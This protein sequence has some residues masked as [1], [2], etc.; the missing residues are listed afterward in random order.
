MQ[1]RFKE[2]Y[3]GGTTAK[4]TFS[5][6]R[7]NLRRVEKCLSLAVVK[8][9]TRRLF[10]LTGTWAHTRTNTHTATGIM[11]E[12][13]TRDPTFQPNP[14]DRINQLSFRERKKYSIHYDISSICVKL[15]VLVLVERNT[16]QIVGCQNMD[17]TWFKNQE[18]WK[19]HN[20]LTMLACGPTS[21]KGEMDTYLPETLVKKIKQLAYFLLSYPCSHTVTLP[22]ATGTTPTQK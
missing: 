15:G 18:E 5:G 12:E 19:H 17:T 14:S 9:H 8:W 20:L 1:K 10:S 7:N 21:C 4:L 13:I 11:W 6:A 22:A 16:N 2:T 3:H